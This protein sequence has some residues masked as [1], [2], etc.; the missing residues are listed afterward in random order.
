MQDSSKVV[1]LEILRE[2][3]PNY[4]LDAPC[5]SGWLSEGLG[6]SCSIDGIDLYAKPNSN[7]RV[8]KSYDLNGG[9]PSDLGEYDCIV[10]CEGLEHFGN[11]E[12]FLRSA[13]NHLNISGTLLITTPNTWYPQAKLQYLLRGFFPSFPN[14][15]GKIKP[16]EH[17]HIIPWTLPQLYLFLELTGF[18]NIRV[19]YQ[20]LSEPKH[21][22]ER[23]FALPQ[24]FYCWN[25][26]RKSVL[27]KNKVYWQA[28]LSKSSLFGRH[29]IVTAEKP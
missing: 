28:L 17:M 27:E 18:E 1:V 7:Y 24:Y 11:P 14:L 16:G 22:Y 15:V 23:I 25:K 8:V 20:P 29:L 10:S 26:L 2:L 4:L 3:S 13:F 19:H 6:A 5:G 12:L 21:L 9:I